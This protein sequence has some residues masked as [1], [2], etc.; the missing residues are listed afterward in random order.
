MW[1]RKELKSNAKGTLKRNYWKAVV[2]SVVLGIVAGVFSSNASN[3]SDA[4]QK[5]QLE[6][7][8]GSMGPDVLLVAIGMI[9]AACLVSGI[10]S[11][12]ISAFVTNPLGIGA[13][14]LLI[15][16]KD[17]SAQMENLLFGFKNSYLNVVKV[18]FL[19]G[20]FTALWSLLLVVPGIIKAYEY[21]MIPY[22]LADNPD[23]D[24]KEAFARS[25]EMMMGNK[26]NAFVLDLS[27]IGWH[28]LG[29]ITLGIVEIFYVLPYNYLTDAELYHALNK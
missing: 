6:Q 11:I 22:L 12:L 14:K 8:F 3:A 25:K 24:R 20:L 10:I 26:W 23:M 9:L 21:R 18:M 15:N 4:V 2:A 17:D 29:G 19:K 13:Q 16:C 7:T 1:N 27:F 5:A 28:L